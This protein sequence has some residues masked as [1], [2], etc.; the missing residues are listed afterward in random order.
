MRYC[1]LIVILITYCNRFE[2][3]GACLNCSKSAITL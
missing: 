2:A 3:P 1:I